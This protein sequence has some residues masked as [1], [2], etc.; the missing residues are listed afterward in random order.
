MFIF[1]SVLCRYNNINIY[2]F[3]FSFKILVLNICSLFSI[4]FF[5]LF[6]LNMMKGCIGNFPV[7]PFC[8][9]PMCQYANVPIGCVVVLSSN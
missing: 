4:S 6:F 7:H 9:V 8:N 1:T 3:I 5:N 2:T